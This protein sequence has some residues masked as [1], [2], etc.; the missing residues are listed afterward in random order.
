MALLHKAAL[1]PTGSQYEVPGVRLVS[2][3]LVSHELTP[4]NAQACSHTQ[5]K[6]RGQR[7][8]SKCKK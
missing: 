3:E 1:K 7:S 8:Q 2:H 4:S 5:K 6:K